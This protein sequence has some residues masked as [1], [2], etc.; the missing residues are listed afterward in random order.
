MAP[1]VSPSQAYAQGLAGSADLLRLWPPLLCLLHV[2]GKF[3]QRHLRY[4]DLLVWSPCQC[5]I[6]GVDPF[7]YKHIRYPYL[8]H[9]HRYGGR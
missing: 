1:T 4:A 2:V 5:V 8:L 6:R 9:R 7:K 3:L